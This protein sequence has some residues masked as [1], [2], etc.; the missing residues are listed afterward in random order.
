MLDFVVIVIRQSPDWAALARDW[1]AGVAIDPPRYQPA[2][3]IGGFPDDI[4][5]LIARWNALSAVDF[6]TCRQRLKEIAQ[7]TLRRVARAM[8]VP[9]GELP[10]AM[11]QL[12]GARFM[13]FFCD[14]DDWF[15][16]DLAAVLSAQD[17]YGV[18]VAVFPMVRFGRHTCT[19]VH[20]ASP[21]RTAVGPLQAFAGRYHTNN[22]GLVSHMWQPA[23]LAA[24]QDH[25]DASYYGDRMGFADRQFDVVIGATNKTPCAA[26]YLRE[27]VADAPGFAPMIDRHMRELRTHA[28]P[29]A[30]AWM[31]E[32]LAATIALFE[33]V[34][35]GVP[36]A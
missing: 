34:L 24:M 10:L 23:H 21:P 1:R 36:A 14:D 6:F 12:E 3:A 2:R 15:A 17:F 5:A 25:F 29:D 9:C 11:A 22:Y 26:S 4:V 30:L 32:P 7:A 20:P 31:R 16:P 27:T 28:I 13:L 19:F 8:V 33:S 18:D 35:A